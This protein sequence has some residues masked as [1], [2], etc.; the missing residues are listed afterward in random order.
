M[1]GWMYLALGIVTEIAG[2]FSMKLSNGMTR[3]IPSILFGFFFIIALYSINMAMKTIDMSV[4][5]AIWSG[6][7]I[8]LLAILGVLFLD[9]PL[10][11]PRLFL[12][13]LIG[14]GVVGLSIYGNP[15]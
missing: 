5:Y 11:F 8:A 12:I 6:V 3:V 4:A 1:N 14:I 2:T 15:H 10:S 9:E 13:G 7:G